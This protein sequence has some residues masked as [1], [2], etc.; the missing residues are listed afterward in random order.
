MENLFEEIMA[1][2]ILNLV[3]ETVIR[4]LEAESHTKAHYS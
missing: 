3:K 2:N 1:P 4:V